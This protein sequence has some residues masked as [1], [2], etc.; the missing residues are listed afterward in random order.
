MA[1]RTDPQLGP[2]I[3]SV[4]KSGGAWFGLPPMS[5]ANAT[6][7]V[8]SPKLG[9]KAH[10]S[11]GRDYIFVKAGGVINATTQVAID[12]TSFEATTGGTSGYFTQADA[13]A[14]GDTFWA[15]KGTP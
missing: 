9:D 1:F 4:I 15:R 10:G 2:A 7:P 11:D 12:G 6:I 13:V 8:V 3:G 5:G 14:A